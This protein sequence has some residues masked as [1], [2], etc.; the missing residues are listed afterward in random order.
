[1]SRV[2]NIARRELR[3]LTSRK[4]YIFMMILVPLGCTFFFL[5]LM[6]EGLPLKIPVGMV[7]LD[8]SSLSRKITRELNATELIDISEGEESFHA[9]MEKIRGGEI[10]GFFLIPDD[11]QKKAL[12]GETPT[13]SFYS[14]MTI[15][16]PGSL[17]FKGFK[18]IAVTTSGG[19]VKN[20]LVSLGADENGVSSLIQP[21]VI[22]SV[23]IGNP[24]LNY[25]IYLSQSFIPCLLAL[26]ILLV[27][28][29]SICE[30]QKRATS[31]QWLT[32]ARGNMA[33]ALAGKLLPQTV[34]FTI[35]GVTIQSLMFGY[36]HFP[37]NCPLPH[38]I[39]AMLLL[40]MAC[41][42]FAVF[43]TEMLPNLRIAMSIV[44]LTGILCFSIAGFSFPVDKMYGGVAIFSYLVPIRYYFLI[45]IDQAL[46]GI[47]IYYSR[48][49]YIALL[50]FT[51]L[52]AIGLRRLAR[53]IA[54]PVYVP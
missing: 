2:L 50:L 13:L 38:I 23:A 45:Y 37:L 54:H 8:H 26:V 25:S 39:L 29:F 47:P 11:F 49:Y 51:L 18:T 36:E 30:E 52:P 22:R 5:N 10:F 53:H 41:Q 16:V 21:M 42:G 40:V 48:F 24:W 43:I 44:S 35:V 7:N 27:T 46:N 33:I 3:R 31:V 32:M 17:T 4:I 9:A 14:N 1:M 12:S 34:I 19:I 28:V 6:N 20:T 15:F